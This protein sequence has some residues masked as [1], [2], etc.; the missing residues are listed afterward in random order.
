MGALK[1]NSTISTDKDEPAAATAQ[2]GEGK[3]VRVLLRGMNVLRAFTPN[4]RWLSNLEIASAAK[5][6][7]STVSRL[8]AQLSESGYLE[9]SPETVRYRLGAAVLTLGYAA[10]SQLEVR[11]IA[12]P[13]LQRLANETDSLVALGTRL[14]SAMVC[15]EVC[16][17]STMLT[18]RVN[19]G[20]R[21]PVSTSALGRALV[22]SMS[23][24]QR[25]EFSNEF[26]RTFPEEWQRL[27]PHIDDAVQQ[28][29]NHGC[30]MSVGTLEEGVNGM[31]TV[32]NFPNDPC[33]YAFG[34]AG[35]AFRLV[36]QWMIST[37]M[38]ILL[39]AKK[40][41]EDQISTR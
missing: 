15:Q 16:F 23:P 36:P 32:L 18:L 8:T 3:S 29:R 6:P 5:L 7:R 40:R 34:F 41:I 12:R 28:M 19:T 31:A 11:E 4:K 1:A 20:S 21:L 35:P 30:Y 2:G 13:H 9:Y 38:P 33:V 39:D 22:G 25:A 17:G 27:A 26:S 10:F 37:A 14:G 24:E